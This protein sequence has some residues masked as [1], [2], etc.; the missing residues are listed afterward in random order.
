[1]IL[2]DTYP[3]YLL[4][5]IYVNIVVSIKDALHVTEVPGQVLE[6]NPEDYPEF[7]VRFD[8]MNTSMVY[9]T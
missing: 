5:C 9:K 8:P 7:E 1:M 3:V 6:I 4:I 2:C